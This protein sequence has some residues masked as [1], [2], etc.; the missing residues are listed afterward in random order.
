MATMKSSVIEKK[1]YLDSLRGIAALSV[2][3]FHFNIGSIFNNAF[4]NSAGLMVDFF[5]VLSGYV[6]ALNYQNRINSVLELIHF[7]R[8][9]FSRLY[10]LH[11]LILVAFIILELLKL[12]LSHFNNSISTMAFTGQYD[13]KFIYTNLFLLQN[14]LDTQL[15]WNAPSWSIS[16]EFYAYFLWGSL[17][18]VPSKFLRTIVGLLIIALI[19]YAYFTEYWGFGTTNNGYLRCIF[20]FMIGAF[21]PVITTKNKQAFN[22]ITTSIILLCV[23]LLVCYS[24]LISHSA[25]IIFPLLFAMLIYALTQTDQNSNIIGVLRN[26]HLVFLGTIS[27]GIYMIHWILWRIVGIVAVFIFQVP[28][29]EG[30]NGQLGL[31]LSHSTFQLAILHIIGL[32]LLVFLAAQSHRL[33]ELP[34]KQFLMTCGKKTGH[35]NS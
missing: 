21:L 34:A 2:A 32:A 9:R 28:V 35:P 19:I 26:R 15:S 6:I 14:V 8:K 24:P 10:P 22:G 17:F 13:P 31:L 3:V 23:I 18:L 25:L 1:D 20:S 30:D 4:T 29:V 7:Q 11:A 27:Y 16:A 5:F 12:F 33:F